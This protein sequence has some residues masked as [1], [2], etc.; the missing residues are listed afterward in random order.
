MTNLQD[1]IQYRKQI[2][3]TLLN[4]IRILN[5]KNIL[6]ENELK[7]YKEILKIED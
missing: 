1:A 3:K 7:L 2:M 6:L 5:E 4:Q